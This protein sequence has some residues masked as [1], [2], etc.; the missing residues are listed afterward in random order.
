M[1]PL[2]LPSSLVNIPETCDIFP[3]D[4]RTTDRAGDLCKFR[5]KMLNNKATTR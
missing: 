2:P 1:S 3:L 5:I 4:N